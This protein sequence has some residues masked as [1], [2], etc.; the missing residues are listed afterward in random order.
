MLVWLWQNDFGLAILYKI[1]RL[2]KG[3]ANLNIFA[4]HWSDSLIAPGGLLLVISHLFALAGFVEAEP[5]S[6]FFQFKKKVGTRIGERR[7]ELILH[8]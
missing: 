3:T 1:V 2:A 7:L 6:L 4:V 5:T 8:R